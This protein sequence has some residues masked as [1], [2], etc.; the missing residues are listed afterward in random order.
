MDDNTRH[1]RGIPIAHNRLRRNGEGHRYRPQLAVAETEKVNG[2][3]RRRLGHGPRVV[4]RE[5]LE[6]RKSLEANF[7]RSQP[8]TRKF[9]TTRMDVGCAGKLAILRVSV[10]R[11][12][13]LTIGLSKA[14]EGAGVGVN[15]LRP[16]RAV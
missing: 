1:L 16:P 14:D 8:L 3:S 11:A 10:L 9:P 6:P 2:E 13:V 7:A 4:A 5:L 15:T 12:S